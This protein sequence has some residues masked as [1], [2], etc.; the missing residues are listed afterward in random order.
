[1]SA[2][3]V[4]AALLALLQ[5]YRLFFRA[6]LGNRCRFEPTCSQYA[7]E[8]L[9]RHGAGTGS[10]LAVGRVLRCHPWCEAGADPVP[11]HAAAALP[12]LFSR[13]G[14]VPL[15]GADDP[16]SIRNHP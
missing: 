12:G 5:V 7:T 16:S 14:L 10:L 3:P 8:A 1:M 4:R 11:E 2:R 6:W 13:L 15:R 9:Q